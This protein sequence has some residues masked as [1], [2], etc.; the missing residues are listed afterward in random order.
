MRFLQTA[1]CEAVSRTFI[2]DQQPQALHFDKP[3]MKCVQQHL[4]CV[5]QPKHHAPSLWSGK[6]LV[7]ADNHSFIEPKNIVPL[8]LRSPGVHA[9]L[10]REALLVHRGWQMVLNYSELLLRE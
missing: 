4:P 5:C 9:F 8:P 7:C 1:L 10:S 3:M 6:Y 2:K